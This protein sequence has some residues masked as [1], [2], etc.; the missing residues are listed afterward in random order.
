MLPGVQHQ[1]TVRGRELIVDRPYSSSPRLHLGGQELPRD[2]WGHYVWDETAAKPERVTI[3]F[4]LRQLA[5]RVDI[6]ATRVHTLPRLPAAA[7]WLLLVV[8]GVG[9]FG[10]AI[11]ACLAVIA[12]MLSAH[13]LRRPQR[14]WANIAAA[15]AVP[16]VAFVLYLMVATLIAR[17]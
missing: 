17:L 7:R 9:A 11:G 3:K 5:P 4:D 1:V 13:L 16:V 15:I 6:G 10:G 2:R 8:L 14:R 12:V